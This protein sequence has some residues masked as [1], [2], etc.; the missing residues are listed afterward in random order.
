[1]RRRPSRSRLA[2]RGP[3]E[4]NPQR[5]RAGASRSRA[6]VVASNG[7][8]TAPILR[9][10]YR[11][12]REG[13]E[14]RRRGPARRKCAPREARAF[15]AEPPSLRHHRARPGRADQTR[16]RHLVVAEPKRAPPPLR[17][18]RPAT[19]ART[20]WSWS[21]KKGIATA[22]GILD[23]F[24]QCPDNPETYNG[25]EDLDGCPDDPDTD[26]DGNHRLQG[27]LHDGARGH[28]R[29]PGPRR[30]PRARQRSRRRP[31]LRGQVPAPAGR[32]DGFQDEGRLPRQR[33]TTT[34]PSPT[35]TTSAR[36]PPVNRAARVL[37]APASSRSARRRSGSP[38]RFQFDFDKATIKPVSFPILDGRARM[39]SATIRTSR[40]RSRATRTTRQREL[41]NQKLSQS[42]ADSVRAYLVFR[43]AIDV[44]RLTLEGLRHVAAARAEQHRGR[45]AH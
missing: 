17:A 26:K 10:P 19:S 1:M 3:S 20:M 13:R 8:A 14:G 30:L 29:L 33:Q 11:R 25:Y 41:Q 6:I 42:R 24:D 43:T 36:T 7:C 22:D 2:R 38:S 28:R 21:R 34:T 18:L 15:A 5:Y 35:S 27:C 45:T 39:P 9:G 4:R 31:R 40:S 23:S 12:P 32:S 37:A 44:G 16:R